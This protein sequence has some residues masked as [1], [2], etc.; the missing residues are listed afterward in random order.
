MNPHPPQD[1]AHGH[2]HPP[3]PDQAA[4]QGPVPAGAAPHPGAAYAPQAPYAHQAAYAP[5]DGYGYPP[6]VY[7]P[8][9]PRMP[10]TVITVR[11]LMFIG[12][13]FGLLFAT[14]FTL[15]FGGEDPLAL[16]LGLGVFGVYGVASLVLAILAGRRHPAVRWTILGFHILAMGYLFFNAVAL[17][18]AGVRPAPAGEADPAGTFRRMSNI[19]TIANIILICV[20]A[21]ARFY[22]NEAAA[23]PG[24]VPGHP[25]HGHPRP[26]HPGA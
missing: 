26:P 10:G 4:P 24:P 5:Q 16:V 6:P 13:A 2:G 21:S 15:S 23:V 12:A 18:D 1:P 14:V 22:R 7:A 3:R 8:V 20:P 17:V 25:P 9:P 19:F 11:V